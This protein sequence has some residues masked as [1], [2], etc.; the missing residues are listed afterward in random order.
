MT[1]PRRPIDA[2]GPAVQ[3]AVDRMEARMQSPGREKQILV[4]GVGNAFLA[5]DGFG[6]AVAAAA[7]AS[8]RSRPASP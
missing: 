5:D 7:R 1:E 4:A 8:R 3:A 6:G 2:D